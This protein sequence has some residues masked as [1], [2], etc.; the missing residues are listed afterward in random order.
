MIVLLV[1]LANAISFFVFLRFGAAAAAA[2]PFLFKL[3]LFLF[4]SDIF[5]SCLLVRLYV[6]ADDLSTFTEFCSQQINLTGERRKEERK[7]GDNNAQR[8][9]K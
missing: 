9:R 8:K 4:G 1:V 2:S 5:S 6:R 7:K 3:L